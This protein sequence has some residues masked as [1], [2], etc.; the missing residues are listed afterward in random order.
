V[1]S[2]TNAQQMYFWCILHV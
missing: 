2:V 1:E